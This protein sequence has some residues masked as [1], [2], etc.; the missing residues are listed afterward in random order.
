[1]AGIVLLAAGCS[2]GQVVEVLDQVGPERPPA[3][4]P[5]TG[6]VVA[7]LEVEST[8]FALHDEGDGCVALTIDRPGMRSMVARSCFSGESVLTKSDTCGW[9]IAPDEWDGVGDGGC[10]VR[11]PAVVYGRI[12]AVPAEYVCIGTVRDPEGVTGA[13]FLETTAAGFILDA[14]HRHEAPAAHVFL[15]NGV[16]YGDQPLDAPSEPI[17]QRCEQETP[18][19]PPPVVHEVLL[20][21]AV[22]ERLRTSRRVVL[23]DSGTEPSGFVGSAVEGPEIDETITIT[24]LNEGLRVEVRLHQSDELAFEPHFPWP[25]PVPAILQGDAQCNLIP[26]DVTIESGWPDDPGGAVTVASEGCA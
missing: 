19:G 3:A 20:R 26:V 2:G 10:D 14:A 4:Q 1:M 16:R 11:L 22:A 7:A 6:P 18:W 21:V 24:N 9:L 23:F 13:R 25:A 8:S 17:Y 5:A 12:D 15:E